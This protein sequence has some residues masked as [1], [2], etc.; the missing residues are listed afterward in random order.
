MSLIEVSPQN[1]ALC[2]HANVAAPKIKNDGEAAMF[3]GSKTGGRLT[4]LE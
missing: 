1:Y 3:A 4:V 2:L